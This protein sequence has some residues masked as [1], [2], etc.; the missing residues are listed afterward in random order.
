MPVITLTTDLG[1]HDYYVGALK[2]AILSQMPEVS[3]VDISHS[4]P[5]FDIRHAA[6]VL[7]QAY[8]NFPKDTVHIL[9]INA[10]ATPNQSHLAIYCD[11]HY[12]IGTDNGIFSL[13]FEKV[14]DKIYDLSNIRQD[15]D[16][17]IFPVKDIFVKA[18]CHLARGGTPEVLG[19]Q[20][21]NF[22]KVDTVHPVFTDNTLHGTVMYVDSYGN[23]VINI[24]KQ[25]FNDSIKGKKFAVEFSGEVINEISHR[26][27]D[28]VAGNILALFNSAGNLEISQAQDSV[29]RLYNLT[30]GSSITIRIT[31]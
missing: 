9:G 18:A 25:F 30:V 2:G 11:G 13:L 7:R 28:V 8:T 27:G 6:Y 4:V 16:L 20:Q 19:V 31:E 21:E 3:I 22:R 17:L 12:F 1:L 23:A 10:E 15:T 26:Y 24:T 14:P 5:A 29:S